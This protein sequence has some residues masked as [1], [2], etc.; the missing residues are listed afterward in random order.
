MSVKNYLDKELIQDMKASLKSDTDDIEPINTLV[1]Q[2]IRNKEILKKPK[3]EFIRGMVLYSETLKW[4]LQNRFYPSMIECL[5]KKN[6][7]FIDTAKRS[8]LSD[9]NQLPVDPTPVA[10]P[11]KP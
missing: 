11:E 8:Q 9:K 6:A 5:F 10:E 4:M 3:E 2:T 7:H 1:I